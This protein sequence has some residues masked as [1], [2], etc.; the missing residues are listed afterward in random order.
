MLCKYSTKRS[1]NNGIRCWYQLDRTITRSIRL[2]TRLA[3][4]G[5]DVG[6]RGRP[7]PGPILPADEDESNESTTAV[8]R[9]GRSSGRV[10]AALI[11]QASGVV[12]GARSDWGSGEGAGR[13]SLHGFTDAKDAGGKPR[14][15]EGPNGI[16]LIDGA[17]QRCQDRRAATG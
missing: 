9:C 8:M 17:T 14:A 16:R 2:R 11:G 1:Q 12:R 15:G 7:S 6:A 5:H 3:T 13:S 10:T 4:V